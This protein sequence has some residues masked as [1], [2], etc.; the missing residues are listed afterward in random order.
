[1]DRFRGADGGSDEEKKLKEIKS[2]LKKMRINFLLKKSA[3]NA[4]QQ[5]HTRMR[6]PG[7]AEG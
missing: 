2:G 6:T 4:Q 5:K 7:R 1:M 3:V